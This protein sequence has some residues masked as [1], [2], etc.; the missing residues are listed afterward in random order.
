MSSL[1]LATSFLQ[2][3][4]FLDVLYIVAFAL[5]IDG[6]ANWQAIPLIGKMVASIARRNLARP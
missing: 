1:P 4:S 2:D 5:F 3:Q 6:P